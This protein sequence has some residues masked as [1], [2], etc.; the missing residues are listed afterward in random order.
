MTDETSLFSPGGKN[1]TEKNMVKKQRGDIGSWEEQKKH[2][3]MHAVV[4]ALY[5]QIS[6][7]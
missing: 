4:P 7:V 3:K 5:S 6:N 2:W 1:H